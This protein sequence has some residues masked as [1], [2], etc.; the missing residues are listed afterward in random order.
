MN[1][2]LLAERVSVGWI[3]TQ[4]SHLIL[5]SAQGEF[6]GGENYCIIQLIRH[7]SN[8]RSQQTKEVT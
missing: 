7:N 1:L 6:K 3:R 5:G 2:E 4:R 8:N